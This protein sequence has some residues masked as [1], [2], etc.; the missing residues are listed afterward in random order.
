[1]PRQHSAPRRLGG[2]EIQA[3]VSGDEGSDP[4]SFVLGGH[5]HVVAEVVSTWHDESFGGGYR[6][7]AWL[8]HQRVFY[9]V[10]TEAGEL[11]D[12]YFDLGERRRRGKG[13]WV[14]HRRLAAGA[15]APE[16]APAQ[17]PPATGEDQPRVGREEA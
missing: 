6:R 11:F 3:E 7:D 8:G 16:A 14:L 17:Q 2:R 9:R 4:K 13:R 10:R 5:K 1:M 12:I 15:P